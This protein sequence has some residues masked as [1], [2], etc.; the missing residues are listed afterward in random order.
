MSG[1]STLS[2]NIHRKAAGEELDAVCNFT[3]KLPGAA[4]LTVSPT[5]VQTQDTPDGAT[6]TDLTIT[7]GQINLSI[8]DSNNVSVAVGKAVL[9]HVTG[10]VA[11]RTYNIRVKSGNTAEPQK[12]VDCRL[13]IDP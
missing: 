6:S 10:G 1:S 12:Y 4:V 9:F 7:A 11:G 2:R 13:I 3:R 5:F 8:V